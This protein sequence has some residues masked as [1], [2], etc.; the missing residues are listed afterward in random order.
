MTSGYDKTLGTRNSPEDEVMPVIVSAQRP[1]FAHDD[2][3]VDERPE[4]DLAEV[5]IVRDDHIQCRP[6]AGSRGLEID[7][8]RTRV[9]A[10]DAD[11][12]LFRR[13]GR[14]RDEPHGEVDVLARRDDAPACP[15]IGRTVK[16]VDPITAARS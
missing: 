3:A 1:L 12:G 5:A 2:V 9:V 6:A 15:G 8:R 11:R 14:G 16:P 13:P 7:D 4:A 10:D